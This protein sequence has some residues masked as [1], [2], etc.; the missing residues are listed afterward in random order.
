MMADGGLQVPRQ[1]R[2][3]SAIARWL[4]KHWVLLLI[5]IGSM[6][7]IG[8]IGFQLLTQKTKTV[9]ITTPGSVVAVVAP[10]LTWNAWLEEGAPKIAHKPV[11][12]LKPAQ[13]YIAGIDL[14]AFAY[15][16][17]SGDVSSK[18]V[19]S[20]LRNWL[21]LQKEQEVRLKVLVVADP[22]SFTASQQGFVNLTINRAAI[23]QYF[24]Q[25][26]A[27]PPPADAMIDLQQNPVAAYL[28]SSL[29]EPLRVHTGTRQGASYL[30]VS[31]WSG[32]TPIDSI[33]VP[34]CI[35][36]SDSLGTC[37]ADIPPVVSAVNLKRL[38]VGAPDPAAEAS[39][40]SF[41]FIECPGYTWAVLQAD[42]AE[43]LTWQIA[44]LEDVEKRVAAIMTDFG[45][46]TSDQSILDTGTGLF[47]V[48]I[49]PEA[50]RARAA[51]RK[52]LS[53]RMHA[54]DAPPL[55]WVRV[56]PRDPAKIFSVPLALASVDGQLLGDWFRIQSTLPRQDYRTLE[57]CI[58]NWKML[59]PPAKATDFQDA[60]KLMASRIKDGTQDDF[61]ND[62]HEFS[63]WIGDSSSPVAEPTL[64]L[65]LSH[66]FSGGIGFNQNDWIPPDNVARPFSRPSVAII[67]GC[68][69][70]HPG[71]DL[72]VQKLNRAGIQAVVTTNGPVRPLMAGQYFNALNEVLDGG[73]KSFSRAHFDAVKGLKRMP[74]S[75]GQDKTYGLKA[76]IF[77]LLGDGSMKV[78]GLK[79]L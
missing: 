69:G 16:T 31:F 29:S 72:F 18:P 57:D 62:L 60:Q 4:R 11:T 20:S 73:A 2:N 48:L 39:L 17:E 10:A 63:E 46:A 19:S 76:H 65:T 78:C 14:A 45:S 41:H 36:E 1:R 25:F 12:N 6:I 15:R 59:L 58:L 5:V 50:T 32:I 27:A 64:L 79:K 42:N 49:P 33:V 71:G 35:S 75:P 61:R 67:E 44:S 34:V 9:Q 74:R 21:D 53:D 52:L 51:V 23:E 37:G 66:Y 28:F 26:V 40:A 38:N 56:D 22:A 24:R 55:I 30:A 70:A 77:T 54:N 43:P 47:N 8:G 13:D 7:V 68:D 3:K